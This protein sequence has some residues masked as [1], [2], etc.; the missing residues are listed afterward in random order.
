M[1]TVKLYKVS[2]LGQ[3]ICFLLVDSSL[4]GYWTLNEMTT[5]A[6][7]AD[8]PLLAMLGCS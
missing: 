1:E 2:N 4:K 6:L 8:L 5:L 7:S 3:W